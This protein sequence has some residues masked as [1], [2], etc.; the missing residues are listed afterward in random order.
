MLAIDYMYKSDNICIYFIPFGEP[1]TSIYTDTQAADRET[2]RQTN[3]CVIKFKAKYGCF[4]RNTKG[5]TGNY[6]EK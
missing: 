2:D 1:C 3:R 5:Q 4:L 6:P